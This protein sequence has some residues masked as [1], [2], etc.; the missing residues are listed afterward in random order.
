MFDTSLIVEK[1]EEYLVKESK[2]GLKKKLELAGKHRLQVLKKMCMDE[3]KSKD[4]IRSV[5]PDDLRELGFEMLAE[6][7]R[8]ALD[9]N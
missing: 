6:L 1:C 7:F 4:D 3:I 2:M 9:Y 8:K 5:V